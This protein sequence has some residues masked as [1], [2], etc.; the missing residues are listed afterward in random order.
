MYLTDK[1]VREV[2]KTCLSDD[3]SFIV[4]GVQFTVYFDRDKIARHKRD[5][6]QM[7]ARL[8]KDF[9]QF[10][11]GGWSFLN[12]CI[13]ADGRQWT[14]YHTTMDMLVCLG[15]AIG[16]VSFPLDRQFWPTLPGGMPYVVVDDAALELDNINQE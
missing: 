11:G 9:M 16:V 14:D 1:N 3:K 4:C 12:M 2:F 7:L 6:A 8:P 15:V 10:G 13:D 5:I